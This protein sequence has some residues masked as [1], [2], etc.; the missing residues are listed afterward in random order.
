[1]GTIIKKGKKFA[2]RYDL[3]GSTKQNRKQ[4]YISGFTSKSEANAALEKIEAKIALGMIRTEILSTVNDVVDR[5]YNEH[6][7]I[8]LAPTSI[9]F[10][11]NYINNFIRTGIGLNSLHD[12]KTGTFTQFYNTLI[13]EGS[14][15]G[16]IDKL[17]RTLRAAFYYCYNQEY[18]STKYIDRV[19]VDKYKS[20][21]I[22]DREN[23]WAPDILIK[24]LPLLK[25]S[26][27]YF[28]IF[29]ALNLALR[30]EET[31]AIHLSD[32]YLDKGY[33]TIRHAVKRIYGKEQIPGKYIKL[34]DEK[35]VLKQTKSGQTRI[36]PLT[37]TVKHFLTNHIASL[38]EYKLLNGYDHQYD[39]YLSIYP[40]G[41][42]ITDRRISQRWKIDMN[43]LQS[44]DDSI[45]R[46]TFHGL[47]HSC[48]SYLAYRGIDM[49]TIQEILGHSDITIT[50][51]IYTHLDMKKKLEAL[52]QIE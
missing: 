19:K 13:K 25:D 32:I 21:N 44:I 47:R 48:A 1:M 2:I 34:L 33:I 12:L 42:L 30:A 15:E 4:K 38:N 11:E 17:H 22:L 39:G 6:V 35:T 45:P 49:K 5:W 16:T 7:L 52:Q 3:P 28:H 31:A 27:I 51:E 50:S 20:K 10:Y 46:I 41:G 36:L 14:T 8:K 23:Y 26:P 43:Y 37:S 29:M 24:A 18:I 9:S 40:E